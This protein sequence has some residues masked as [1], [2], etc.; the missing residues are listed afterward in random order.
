MAEKSKAERLVEVATSDKR[1][2]AIE[3]ATIGLACLYLKKRL[4][5]QPEA[6][7]EVLSRDMLNEYLPSTDGEPE[8]SGTDAF[9]H[10]YTHDG[11]STPFKMGIGFRQNGE[12]R[13]IGISG[14]LRAVGKAKETVMDELAITQSSN[15]DPHLLDILK[16]RMTEWRES[17]EQR[18]S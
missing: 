5:G 10:T 8:E 6:E 1:V 7:N 2:I 15:E 16:T 13:M 4:D 9:V 14:I 17:L 12:Y 3:I 18:G 11:E